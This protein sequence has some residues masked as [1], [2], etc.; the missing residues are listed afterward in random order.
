M[1]GVPEAI[2]S[3]NDLENV[4]ALPYPETVEVMRRL[5]GDILILGAGGKMGPS[6]AHLAFNACE[7]AGVRKRIIAVSRFT[8]RDQR[9]RLDK[10]GVETLAC[11]LFDVDALE[12][13]PRTEHVI[14]MVGRKFGVV[15]VESD[16]WMTNAALP[17]YVAKLYQNANLVVFSTGCVYALV[18]PDSGGSLETD[19][20]EPVGEY[21]YSCLARERIFQ[22]A[23]AQYGTKVLL[24]RLNYSI[25]LRY[26]VLVDIAQNVFAGK[27]VDRSVRVVNVIW[28]GDANNRAL[29]SLE[30]TASPA[31]ILN[32]TGPEIV[33]V[34]SVARAF[35]GMF[36]VDVCFAGVD[37]GKAYL[38]DARQSIDLF[39][40]PTVSVERMMQWIAEW[41]RR[42]GRTLD[43]PTL[44]QVT[45]GQFL[46]RKNEGDTP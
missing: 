37:S 20:P 25:D 9:D 12:R 10:I 28:Q 13:L 19:S 38:S 33:Q 35:A 43:K 39:G 17:A 32:V 45:D 24:F 21:A 1:N 29:L 5:E 2:T 27:P 34:E 30:H 3:E 6:L 23:S 26:G 40:P 16:I 44:F 41:I 31:K 36:G 46:T 18:P 22:H 7:R 11:D 4:L 8:E 14:F 15:G 42:G